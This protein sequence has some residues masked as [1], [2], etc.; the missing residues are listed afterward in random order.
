MRQKIVKAEDQAPPDLKAKAMTITDPAMA[1]FR[2]KRVDTGF[3]KDW[4][5]KFKPGI[6]AALAHARVPSL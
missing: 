4:K 1:A 3:Y 2:K 5:A 6:W